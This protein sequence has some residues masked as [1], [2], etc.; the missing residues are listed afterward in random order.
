[1]SEHLL[2][3]F[4]PHTVDEAVELLSRPGAKP[5]AAPSR[6]QPYPYYGAKAVVDMAKLNLETITVEAG[7]LWVGAY[8]PLQTLVDDPRIQD[9]A[10]GV[11]AQAAIVSAHFGLR[12][13]ATLGGALLADGGSPELRLA[14]L[15]L[16]ARVRL[17][18]TG[19]REVAF[20]DYRPAAGGLLLGVSFDPT[21]I[22]G[23]ALV[24]VARTP[25]AAAIVAAAAV[26][27]AEGMARVAVAG[28]RSDPIY[29]TG[30]VSDLPSL[31]ER[32]L[33]VTA[34]VADYWG[35]ADYRRMTAAVVAGRALT[36][37]HQHSGKEN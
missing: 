28:V 20:A 1:M 37:A 19:S 36:Q 26:V 18:W 10:G 4:Q 8:V 30:T 29:V 24:R 12:N 13:L 25:L 33:A 2:E 6:W 3:Y 27:T 14:L 23:G 34:P 5:I 22:A 17:H 32:A 7:R 9:Y 35:S 16:D 15:V 21:S 31:V 11:L